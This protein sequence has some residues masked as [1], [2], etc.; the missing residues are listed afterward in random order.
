MFTRPWGFPAGMK[1]TEP[2]STRTRD[3]QL[4]YTVNMER[5]VIARRATL[6]DE[7]TLF[8]VRGL[9]AEHCNRTRITAKGCNRPSQQDCGVS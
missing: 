7:D 5:D 6:E 1:T 4:I 8:F 3:D 9:S 2:A